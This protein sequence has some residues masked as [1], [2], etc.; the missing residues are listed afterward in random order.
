MEENE[1]GTILLVDDNP[2]NLKLLSNLLSDHDY[3]VRVASNGTRA[4][5]TINKE[6]PS[7]VL[8]D[9]MMPG[10]DGYEVCK[11]LKENDNTI[12]I[13]IIFITA[14]NE[15]SD[16]V[17]AFSLGGVD[18]ITKPFKAKE[19][20]A[21]VK[22]HITLRNLQLTLERKNDELQKANDEVKILRG[23][24]PICAACKKIRYNDGSWE[25]IEVYIRD[26]SEAEFSHGIC[27]DCATK[28]YPELNKLQK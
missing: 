3:K 12:G 26:H 5:A 22:T 24:L 2:D 27:K 7:L 16:I 20:L 15:T 18:Y 8:L 21:R 10:L 23:C 14:L 28:L 25:Q 11:Q 4:L 1:I 6:M 19:V 13:P 9:I 17:K